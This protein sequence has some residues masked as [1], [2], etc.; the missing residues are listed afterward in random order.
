M[1]VD[2]LFDRFRPSV[3][4]AL[5]R[6]TPPSDALP[7]ALHDAMWYSLFA[8]GKRLRPILVAV[9]FEVAGGRGAG[10]EA[11]ASAVEMVHTYSLIHDDLPAMDDD[12]LRRG[13][14]TCHKVFGEATAILAGDAL[15]TRA[16]EVLSE[17]VDDP[18]VATRLVAELASAAGGAGMV[19]G[20]V[21]DLGSAA[22]DVDR[23]ITETIA[24]KKTGAL[25]RA[26]LKMGA[27]AAAGAP[28]VIEKLGAYGERVG[29]A[30]QAID[31]IL[32][33][34][35]TAEELGK[36]PGK[37]LKDAKLTFPAV[38]GIE[39]ARDQAS[40]WIE[41]AKARIVDLDGS[42]PLVELADFILHRR[43]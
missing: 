31:D 25:I 15:L 38:L 40:R 42:D 12:D 2:A 8:G 34:L 18:N 29:L 30:F 14:P 5:D 24:Q 21:L 10:W 39:G 23:K 33:R 22:M 28:Q 7:E 20:Q 26:S 9:A 3:E 36:T 11:P 16:F 37:D 43:S 4:A 35:S 32:D 27:I 6:L 41:E 13:K 19:G 17:E 1:T